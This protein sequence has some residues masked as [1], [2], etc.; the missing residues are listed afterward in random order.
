[1]TQIIREIRNDSKIFPHF[2][3][4]DLE[5]HREALNYFSNI[6]DI[7]IDIDY[8]DG[9]LNDEELFTITQAIK[10]IIS[11][12]EELLDKKT[13]IKWVDWLRYRVYYYRQLYMQNEYYEQAANLERI[14]SKIF[15][16]KHII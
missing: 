11:I 6:L 5:N 3:S 2:L 7:L 1:M 14:F 12:V 15:R 8:C 16:K 10:Q 9:F 13:F 4:L